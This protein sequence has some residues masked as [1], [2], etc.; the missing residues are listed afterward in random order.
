MR[1]FFPV[2]VILLTDGIANVGV[3]EPERIA[4]DSK[5]ENSEGVDLSTIGVGTDFNR[6]LLAKLAKS[7]RGQ[8]HFVAD[9]KDIDKV[10]VDNPMTAG[11]TANPVR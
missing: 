1:P 6:E 8:F 9:E 4:S 10:F 7:G 2:P 3:T 5:R 11:S